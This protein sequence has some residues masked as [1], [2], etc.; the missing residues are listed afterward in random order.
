MKFRNTVQVL[1]AAVVSLGL[2]FG[3]SS[4]TSSYTVGY[5]YVVGNNATTG[6]NA[7]SGIVTG[8]KIDHNTGKLTQIAGTP[9]GSGGSNP[10]RAVMPVGGTYLYVLNKGTGASDANI[11]QFTIGGNGQLFPVASYVSQGVSPIRLL[12]DSSGKFLY[13]LD[14]AVPSC[15]TQHTGEADITVFT[16]DT[17]TGRLSPVVNG[18]TGATETAACAAANGDAANSPLRYFPL[19]SATSANSVSAV[20]MLISGGYILT[21]YTSGGSSYVYPLAQNTTTGNLTYPQATAQL[22]TGVV[23]P[24]AITG[25]SGGTIYVL[26]NGALAPSCN[27]STSYASMIYPYTIGSYGALTQLPGGAVANTNT[28]SNPTALLT[29]AG[30]RFVYVANAGSPSCVNVNNPQSGMSGYVIDSTSRELS[31]IAGQPFTMGSGPR[32]LVE[33]PSDQFVYSAD[34]N[35]N[36]VVGR[37]IDHGTGL[38][39][40]LA[41]PEQYDL[42]GPASW[43]LVTGRTD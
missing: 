2:I 31:Y 7:Q 20:D 4:C 37:K 18:N 8:F 42:N 39:V 22:L 41:A 19:P 12:V 32:C 40:N 16:I 14:S 36:L 25:L 13:V 10:V 17:A 24:T 30:G 27:T 33:D 5:L 29:E 28:Y 26:D 1:L 6:V 21:L 9:V 34:Y 23:A 35:D 11:T 15:D 38:L 3:L 43:C